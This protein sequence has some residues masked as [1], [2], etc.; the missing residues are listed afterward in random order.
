MQLPYKS[1][2]GEPHYFLSKNDLPP[3]LNIV[4]ID[5]K[6]DVKCYLCSKVFQLKDM[7]NHVGIH[8][9]KA[10]RQLDDPLLDENGQVCRIVLCGACRW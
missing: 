6:V 10:F 8:L 4:K 1:S 5:G 2:G 7:R 9:L 3:Q